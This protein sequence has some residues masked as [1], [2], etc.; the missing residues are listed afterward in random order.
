MGAR[1]GPTWLREAVRVSGME[2]R[3]KS[4]HTGPVWGEIIDLNRFKPSTFRRPGLKKHFFLTQPAR[5]KNPAR[6][7]GLAGR[8][9]NRLGQVIYAASILRTDPSLH[10][11]RAPI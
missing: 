4:R 11:S 10:W 6:N 7:Q 2:A 8:I 9:S 1:T 5:K 3:R